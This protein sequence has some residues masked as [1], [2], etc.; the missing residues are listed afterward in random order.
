[1]NAT[2]A[3]IKI[4][5][6]LLCDDVRSELGSK[7]TIVGVYKGGI[8]IP[9]IPWETYITIWT[10]V[11]WS[12]DGSLEIWGR[13]V[14]PVGTPVGI[15]GGTANAEMQGSFSSLAFRGMK[16]SLDMEGTH[17]FQYQ[18]NFGD[19]VSVLKFPIVINRWDSNA[20]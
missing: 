15:T 9:V 19:W 18:T 8:A 6:C 11:V 7:E 2:P 10:Q 16:M 13:V 1:M 14:N 5:H 17:E 12:G 20:S 3:G 4:V